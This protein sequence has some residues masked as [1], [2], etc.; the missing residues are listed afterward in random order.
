MNVTAWNNFELEENLKGLEKTTKETYYYPNRQYLFWLEG[1]NIELKSAS[2]DEI[3]AFFKFLSENHGKPLAPA[4]SNLCVSA[5]RLLYKANHLEE[6]IKDVLTKRVPQK[7]P[8]VISEEDI[9]TII[10]ASKTHFTRGA[11]ANW[12]NQR[13]YFLLSFFYQTGSRI[14]EAK[15]L[16]KADFDFKYNT[17]K[18]GSKGKEFIRKIDSEWLSNFKEWLEEQGNKDYVFKNQNGKTFSVRT[19]RDN[20]NKISL[21]SIGKAY[22]PHRLRASHVTHRLNAGET[23]Q[24]VSSNLHNNTNTTMRYVG[25]SAISIKNMINP[26]TKNKQLP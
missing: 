15:K 12:K 10:E 9:Q 19:I 24:S 16:K 22:S 2:H 13:N 21:E 23:L 26:F 1:Q 25:A 17:V 20:I 18:V 7:I 5:L 6:N 8:I 3:R 14:S 11:D 4:Y